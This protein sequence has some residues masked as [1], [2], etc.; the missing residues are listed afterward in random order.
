M[1]AK[2][3]ASAKSCC[4][5]LEWHGTRRLVDG[6]V[7]CRVVPH[8]QVVGV[9]QSRKSGPFATIETHLEGHDHGPSRAG[10]RGCHRHGPPY[11]NNDQNE[12]VDDDDDN[13]GGG[14][15]LHGRTVCR[16]TIGLLY[17]VTVLFYVVTVRLAIS[18]LLEA[19]KHH[20]ISLGPIRLDRTIQV[21]SQPP[22]PMVVKSLCPGQPCTGLTFYWDLCLDIG[23]SLV[24]TR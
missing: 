22:A 8:G 17:V 23:R 9:R 6:T 16:G 13:G 12:V 19:S 11:N 4:Q 5:H 7:V 10:S 18:K 2:R 21:S 3:R 1:A 14:G 15:V 20:S 24:N